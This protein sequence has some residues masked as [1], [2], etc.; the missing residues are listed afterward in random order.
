MSDTMARDG[1]MIS[2]GTICTDRMYR[3]GDFALGRKMAQAGWMND[4][5]TRHRRGRSL[6]CSIRKWNAVVFEKIRG[7]R[8]EI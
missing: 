2:T 3:T 1:R 6:S 4:A 5:E 7:V 8:V